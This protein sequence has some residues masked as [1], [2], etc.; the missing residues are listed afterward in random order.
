MI[1]VYQIINTENGKLY[2]GQTSE[3]LSRYLYVQG[4]RAKNAHK[5]KKP[6]LYAAIRKYG[7][8]KFQIF[9]I[10]ATSSH[11]DA[12]LWETTLIKSHRT[13]DRR[14]G[15]NLADGGGGRPGLP[16]WNKGMKM[17]ADFCLKNS[18]AQKKR[19]ST[20]PAPAKG[21]KRS[22]EQ[23]DQIKQTLKARG[24][25]PSAE[26]RRKG[27]IASCL[28]T[29]EQRAEAARKSWVTRRSTENGQ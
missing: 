7:I 24:I 2:I 6:V 14:F 3:K 4:W 10:L 27:T 8:E 26:A 18:V 9:P 12:N 25:A 19:F 17:S 13:Q 29:K 21:M 5:Y 11:K 16:A 23:K 15:Y 20:A 22:Q 1:T 28:R